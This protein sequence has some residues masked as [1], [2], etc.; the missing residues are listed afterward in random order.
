MQRKAAE[1]VHELMIYCS[2]ALAESVETVEAASKEPEAK[3]YRDA[4]NAL[5][6]TMLEEIMVPIYEQHADL[7]PAELKSSMEARFAKAVKE[8]EAKK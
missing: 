3:R 4:V 8:K 5:L 2:G 7:I 1:E 6:S